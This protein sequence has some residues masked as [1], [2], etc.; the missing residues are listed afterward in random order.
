MTITISTNAFDAILEDRP[1]LCVWLSRGFV[2]GDVCGF[3]L[4]LDASSADPETLERISSGIM[5][6]GHDGP[7]SSLKLGLVDGERPVPL[8]LASGG[9]S[10]GEGSGQLAARLCIEFSTPSEVG[11]LALTSVSPAWAHHA[12]VT[13]DLE[14]LSHSLQQ[15]TA[16]F[17]S[18]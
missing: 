3:D 10:A 11:P 18:R 14:A 7:E 17:G 16:R 4:L 1:G 5:W 9:A 6:W 2:S 12:A 13:F 8:T 15:W